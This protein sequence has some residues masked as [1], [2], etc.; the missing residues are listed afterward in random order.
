LADRAWLTLELLGF[1]LWD[2]PPTSGYSPRGFARLFSDEH[3]SS[4]EE[5]DAQWAPMSYN[6]GTRIAHL[7]IAYLDERVP[8]ASR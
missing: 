4:S 3:P 1:G 8:N 2:K 7:L 6:D 5:A